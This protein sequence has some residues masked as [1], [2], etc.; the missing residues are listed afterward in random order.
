MVAV[1]HRRQ[2]IGGSLMAAVERWAADR[3]CA[4]VSLATRRASDFFVAIGYEASAT[5]HRNL[6]TGPQVQ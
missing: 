6:L 2:G 5:F 4:Y 1:G 3:G